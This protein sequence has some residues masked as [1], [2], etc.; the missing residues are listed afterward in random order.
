M[1][2]FAVFFDFEAA[3]SMAAKDNCVV[4]FDGRETARSEVLPST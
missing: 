2:E 3:I 1:A 4:G